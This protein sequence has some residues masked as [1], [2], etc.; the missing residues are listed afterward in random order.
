MKKTLYDKKMEPR[1]KYCSIGI[2]AADEKSV[3]CKKRGIMDPDS[4]CKRFKY[5]PLK[6]Q[7]RRAPKMME[8]SEDEFL[9]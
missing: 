5:D 1:C 9:L 8:F 6:R 3:I 7:P 2:L 4:Q